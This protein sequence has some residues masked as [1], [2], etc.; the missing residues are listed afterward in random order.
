MA[1]AY[2]NLGI[3][4]YDQHQYDHALTAFKKAIEL[5]PELLAPYFF[6]GVLRFRAHAYE[7]ALKY[8][9]KAEVG[10]RSN[11]LIHL[12]LGYTH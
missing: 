5:K 2:S 7:D 12:Y 10:D 9:T 3:L 4:Y 11:A 1:E 6:L 8:L